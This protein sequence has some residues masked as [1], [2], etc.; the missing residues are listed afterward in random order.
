MY[1]TFTDKA[2]E[3]GAKVDDGTNSKDLLK[4]Y[5]S[6]TNDIRKLTDQLGITN[7]IENEIGMNFNELASKLT[8]FTNSA[9]GDVAW[10]S[11]LAALGGGVEGA[12]GTASAIKIGTAAAAKIAALKG[13]AVGLSTASSSIPVVGWI[14]TAIIAAGL[15]TYAGVSTAEAL[16]ANNRSL[17]N[18]GKEL[19]DALVTNLV[20][21][22][23]N[24]QQAKQIGWRNKNK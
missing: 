7:D 2:E 11:I 15:A 23:Y 22:S 13:T 4:D 14:V 21:Y 5:T 9:E 17:A 16:K 12:G 18:Q 6:L 20:Q 3:L 1:S 10:Q 19:Y 8:E 24:K